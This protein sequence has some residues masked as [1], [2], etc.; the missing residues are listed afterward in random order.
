VPG[1]YRWWTAR[2]ALVKAWGVGFGDSTPRFA[3]TFDSPVEIMKGETELA[4][5]SKW[6]V[7]EIDVGDSHVASLASDATVEVISLQR[8]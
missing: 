4:A 1:F 2:E 6:L 8:L 7:R 5:R 3:V